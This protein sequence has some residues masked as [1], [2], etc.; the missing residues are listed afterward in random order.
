MKKKFPIPVIEDLFD[1]LHGVEFYTKIDLRAGYHQVRM[2]PEDIH[3]TTFRT[4]F[5][6]FEYLVMPFGLTNAP[7]TFQALMNKMFAHLLRKYILVFFDD[8]LVYSRTLP[9]HLSHL[10]EVLQILRKNRLYAK[11]SK[12]TFAAPQVEYLGHIISGKGV[13]TDS[14]KIEAVKD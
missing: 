6:H 2:K 1:E 11:L 9:E 7:A 3:K 10:R 4:Y 14:K 5:G 13:E 8:I 12:C